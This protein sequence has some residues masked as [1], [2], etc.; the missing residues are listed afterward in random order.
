MPRR[1]ACPA[2]G[3]DQIPQFGTGVTER[4][5]FVHALEVDPCRRTGLEHMPEG[6]ASGSGGRGLLDGGLQPTECLAQAMLH[7]LTFDSFGV[8]ADRQRRGPGVGPS[9]DV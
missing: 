7:V 5:N 4:N 6:P 3:M 9:I 1:A 8:Q 2:C